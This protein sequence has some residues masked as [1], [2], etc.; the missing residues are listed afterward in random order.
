MIA[1]RKHALVAC[2]A[3]AL[4]ACD[5]KDVELLDDPGAGGAGRSSSGGVNT[6][7]IVPGTPD[8]APALF[9]AD[10]ARDDTGKDA[11]S[12]LYP[13]DETMFPRNLDRVQYQWSAP[14]KLDLFEVRFDSDAAHVRYY[15]TDRFLLP[16]ADG[17]RMLA[18]VNAGSSL[19]MTV[20]GL[21]RDKP[22]K[23]YGS[24]SIALYFSE[25][26]VL[27]ALYYWSTGAQG[28]MR[29]QISAPT[30]T[31]FYTDPAA[32]NAGTCAACHSVS[33]DGRKLAVGYGGERLRVIDVARRSTLVPAGATDAPAMMMPDP[34]M[35]PA[36]MKDPMKDPMA[37]PMPDPMAGMGPEYGWG[38][39]NPDGTRLIYATKGALKLIDAGTGAA[40]GDVKLPDGYRANYPDW[41]PDGRYVAIAYLKSD[42]DTNNK[43]ISGSS[44]ARLAANADDTFG[45]PEVLLA[46]NDKDDTLYFPAYSPDSRW[47]AFVRAKG[48]SKDNPNAQ[49]FLLAADGSGE[50]IELERLNHRVGGKGTS[51]DLP[52]A[53][54]MPKDMPKAMMMDLGNSM[55]TWAPSSRP[56]IFWLAFS[57]IRDYGDVLVDAERDQLWA[58]AIDPARIGEQDPSFAAFWLPFQDPNEGNHRAFW[59]L[60]SEDVCSDAIE[61][62]DQLDNDCNGLVDDDCCMPSPEVCGDGKDNDCDG[63]EDEHCDCADV[64]TCDNGQDDDCDSEV[65][66]DCLI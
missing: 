21:A 51:N 7:V 61:I 32:P 14:D 59:A 42:K 23:I 29:A 43:E 45:A 55:P 44:L 10:P 66:E 58:A 46:S 11:P 5:A 64:E 65:D 50:P 33:R 4:A 34:M 52:M 40:L 49:L 18:S 31:K 38:S 26:E 36:P 28:V 3:L 39:F 19:Q 15:T 47:L 57:S 6:Q 27:G 25:S 48:K 60:A 35:M 22:D 13:S 63:L 54:D 24:R 17:F 2:C 62:C 12:I 16:D 30:A 56:G 37:D 53:M 20:R 9:D 8:D 1:R 41:S